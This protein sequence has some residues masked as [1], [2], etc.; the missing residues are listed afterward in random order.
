MRFLL[1][2]CVASLLMA[3]GELS[4]R[5]APGF[6]LPDVKGEQHDLQD[7]RGKI[8]LLEIMQTNCPH[9]RTFSK[10]LDEAQAKYAGRVV[11]LS[12]VNPP[13]TFNTVVKYTQEVKPA[14][15]ILFDTGQMAISYMKATPAKPT[16]DLPH[17]FIINADGMIVNDYG[18]EAGPKAI[19]EGR[20][21]FTELDRILAAKP[22]PPAAKKK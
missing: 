6:S 20:A 18:Y 15:P 17:L 3:S 4:G 12:V 5:R 2:L 19:F 8:F 21:L 11:A 16:I 1:A 10:V 14:F 13:D 22:A 7:Y 9:C